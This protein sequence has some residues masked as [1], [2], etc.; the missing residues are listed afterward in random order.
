[1]QHV[2]FN[3]R[4]HSMWNYVTQRLLVLLLVTICCNSY[5]RPSNFKWSINWSVLISEDCSLL[6]GRSSMAQWMHQISSWALICHSYWVVHLVYWH[7]KVHVMELNHAPC[8]FLCVT[9]FNFRINPETLMIN[10]FCGIIASSWNLACV[11]T[12]TQ[13]LLC[14]IS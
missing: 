9:D 7:C 8:A 5:S 1:M 2:T 12:G 4:F 3:S 6:L 14:S 10:T 13:R 11:V